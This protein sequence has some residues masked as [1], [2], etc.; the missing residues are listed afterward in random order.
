MYNIQLKHIVCVCVCWG[1]GGGGGEVGGEEEKGLRN[2]I[3][4]LLVFDQLWRNSS[5]AF[6]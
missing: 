2:V 4:S 5:K 6:L 1:G 3:N